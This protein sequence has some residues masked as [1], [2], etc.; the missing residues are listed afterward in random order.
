MYCHDNTTG[1]PGTAPP[2]GSP[3]AASQSTPKYRKSPIRRTDPPAS[4]HHAVLPATVR[5]LPP[6]QP[7]ACLHA[8]CTAPW[9]EYSY[10]RQSSR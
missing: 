2:H 10:G 5:P 4:A 8:V 1:S 3:P 9:Q 7:A 6:R